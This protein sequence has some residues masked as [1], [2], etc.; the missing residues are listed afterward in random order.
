MDQYLYAK[1]PSNSPSP[2]PERKMKESLH[3]MKSGS[4]IGSLAAVSPALSPYIG[5]KDSSDYE[6]LRIIF[7]VDISNFDL[8]R[9]E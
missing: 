8:T 4:S 9:Q 5:K 3:R 2:Q 6:V 1:H 7:R